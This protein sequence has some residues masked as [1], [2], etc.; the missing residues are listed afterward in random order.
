M[1]CKPWTWWKEG[2]VATMAVGLVIILSVPWLRDFFALDL[3]QWTIIIQTAVISAAGIVLLE[4]A[5]Q[6]TG[7][8]VRSRRSGLNGQVDGA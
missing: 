8:R 1:L 7:W 5:W 3:P 4:L 6:V 2:L